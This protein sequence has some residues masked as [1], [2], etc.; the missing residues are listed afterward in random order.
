MIIVDAPLRHRSETGINT[1]NYLIF[2]KF[3]KKVMTSLYR[4]L[5]IYIYILSQSLFSK[6]YTLK[7]IER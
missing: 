1:V 2:G 5:Y 4:L 6:Q 3:S 7:L